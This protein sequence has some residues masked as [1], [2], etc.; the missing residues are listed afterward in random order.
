M[1][2]RSFIAVEI[3]SEIKKALA[4]SLASIKK[5]LPLSLIRWVA[6]NNVHLTLKFLGVVAP[7]NLERLAE[8]LKDEVQKIEAFSMSIGGLGAFPTL[9]RASIIWVGLETS[10]A[11]KSL[12]RSTDSVTSRLGYSTEERPFSPHLTIGRVKQNISSADLELIGTALKGTVIGSLGTV[13]VN[14]VHI[15]KSDLMAGGPVYS[16]LY[17]LPMKLILNQHP[18]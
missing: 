12:L 3:P 16:C 13:H 14:A 6:P 10:N 11:L 2:L 1:M 15:F 4:A 7:A 18:T 17:S 9:R 8:V 5:A